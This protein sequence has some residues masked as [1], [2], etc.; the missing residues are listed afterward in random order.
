MKRKDLN[1]ALRLLTKMLNNPGLE[2]GQREQLE[3][4]KRE[5]TDTAGAGKLDP[6]K[7]FLGRTQYRERSVGNR[8]T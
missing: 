4:A 6:G 3:R 5:L 1:D 7:L 8:R 2:T